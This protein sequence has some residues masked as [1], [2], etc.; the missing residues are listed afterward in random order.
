MVVT[1]TGS[2]W[3]LDYGDWVT[4]KVSSVHTMA[5]TQAEILTSQQGEYLLTSSLD[6]TVKFSNLMNLE[7]TL[8]VYKPRRQA[9]CFCSAG[10]FALL[11]FNDECYIYG[12]LTA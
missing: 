7:Q 10:G 12:Q 11:A 6:G 5:I 8:E 9:K 2:L 1:K 4:V 3:L